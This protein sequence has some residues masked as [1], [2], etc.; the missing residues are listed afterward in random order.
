[1]RLSF[2][3]DNHEPENG[4]WFVK[5]D[6]FR[7]SSNTLFAVML[8]AALLFFYFKSEVFMDDVFIYLRVARNIAEGIGPVLNPGDGHFAVTSPLWVYLLALGHKLGLAGDLIQLSELMTTVFL[9]LASWLAYLL[10]R[11]HI[12]SWAVWAPFPIL[13]NFIS[14]TTIGG[15][16]A[17]V[18]MSLFGMLYF[19]LQKR[20]YWLTGLMAAIGYLGRAELILMLP[21]LLIYDFFSCR[22][23]Q[24]S[25]RQ[26]IGN[27]LKLALAFAPAVLLW[28]AFYFS[29]FHTLFPNTLHTK[30]VQGRSGQWPLYYNQARPYIITHMFR[31]A[32]WL[33]VPL[34]IGLFHFRPASL[35][36]LSFTAV[37]YYA[38]SWLV[39][40][41]YHWYFYD[42]FILVPLF[43]ILGTIAVFRKLGALFG[44]YRPL[45]TLLSAAALVCVFFL[46][47]T[48][49]I[50]DQIKNFK[51][52]D[53]LRIYS[54]AAATIRS[55]AKPHD[56]LLTVE[57]GII[58]YLLP[59]LNIRDINGIASVDVTLQNINNIDHFI[60][61]YRPRFLFF[62]PFLP[63]NEPTRVVRDSQGHE[64]VYRMIHPQTPK[65]SVHL[66]SVFIRET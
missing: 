48:L 51:K 42:F 21:L 50:M 56:T 22:K 16:I 60:N 20:N 17:I 45:K 59:D 49:T 41:H 65:K 4:R 47:D 2:F 32:K 34:L 39:I 6:R 11:P 63:Q 19:H 1:M 29:Q 30:I 8:G 52:D 13:F 28:H 43:T 61:V 36:L 9:G 24:E 64:A 57:I 23:R 7:I 27:W 3:T 55:Q 25:V 44:K 38:Y 12:G 46:I 40:P 66:G 18:Y 58:G 35:L 62:P 54:E 10:L 15:E 37:H 5:T 14:L 53:R 31:G 26:L 33:V